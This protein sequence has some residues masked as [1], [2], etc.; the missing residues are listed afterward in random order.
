M[1]YGSVLE[2]F[3]DDVEVWVILQRAR[4]PA[5]WK[6]VQ[7]QSK[8]VPFNE[9]S[10]QNC[11]QND[12]QTNKYLTKI[13]LKSSLGA[14]CG[15][16]GTSCCVVGAWALFAGRLGAV[17]GLSWGVSELSWKRFGSMLARSGVA[18]KRLEAA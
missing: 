4:H 7:E 11:Y 2:A 10:L 18:W 3:C 8:L 13:I 14:S 12:P 9:T 5:C 17:L 6:T 16:L 1:G 15:G